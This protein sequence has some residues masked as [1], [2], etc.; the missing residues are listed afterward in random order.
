MVSIAQY[1]LSNIISTFSNIEIRSRVLSVS[2]AISTHNIVPITN[3]SPMHNYNDGPFVVVIIKI[4]I[5]LALMYTTMNI[6][7]SLNAPL[8]AN[9]Q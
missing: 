1:I 9:C 8:I 4:N 2:G 3:L 6:H 7:S 5:S